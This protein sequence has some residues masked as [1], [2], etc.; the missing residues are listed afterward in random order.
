MMRGR[1]PL[2]DSGG[3]LRAAL[4]L[5]ALAA[6]VIM[7]DLFSTAARWGCVAV[8]AAVAAF[9]LPE[10]RRV[11][12]GWWEIFAVGLGVTVLAGLLSGAAE[13]LGGILAL[14]GGA[15][16]IVAAAIGFPPGE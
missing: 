3:S 4:I 10:R 2:A 13:T 11:G 1:Q 16:I 5:A 7:L 14:V 12:S 6:A 15:L 8:I 9:T